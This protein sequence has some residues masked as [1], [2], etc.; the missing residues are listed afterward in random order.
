MLAVL[1][2]IFQYDLADMV[3]R[4]LYWPWLV[5]FGADGLSPAGYRKISSIIEKRVL[6]I[7]DNWY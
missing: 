4:V 5:K 7:N 3:K 2:D 1:N 6:N